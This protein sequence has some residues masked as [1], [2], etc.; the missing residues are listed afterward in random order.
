MNQLLLL[1][2]QTEVV[3]FFHNPV[4]DGCQL[5]VVVDEEK[6][7]VRKRNPYTYCFMAPGKLSSLSQQV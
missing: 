3:L 5:K 4:A 6:L 2:Q 1:Q 7:L